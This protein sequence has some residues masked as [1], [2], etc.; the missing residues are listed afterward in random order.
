MGFRSLHAR[1]RIGK[2]APMIVVA[3]LCIAGGADAQPTWPAKPVRLV[4]PFPPGGG[5][6]ILGRAMAQR[7]GESVGQAVLL[8]NRP[9]AGGNLGAEI[10]ARAAPDGY[11]LVLVAPGFVISPSLYRKLGYDPFK[12][13]DPVSL[14][15]VIPNLIAVHPSVPAQ[16]VKDLVAFARAHPGKINFGSGGVGTSNHLA[17]ELLAVRTGISV[18]HVPYK[19]AATAMMDTVAGNVQLI[20]IG[21]GAAL[22]Q[23]K[24][25]KLRALA[26]LTPGRVPNAPEIPTIAE[27][28]YPGLEVQTWYAVFAPTKTPSAIVRRLNTELSRAMF[29][30]D[31]R[32]R[33][34]SI[35][36]EPMK[37][38]PEELAKF[39]REDYRRWADVIK[40]ANLRAEQ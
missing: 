18:V 13:F 34:A 2:S 35:G 14:V 36:A 20:T 15:A 28:G 32:E 4:L 26:T 19:G 39:I 24:A 23:V 6:D 7:L 8:D 38:S 16:S 3:A 17:T 33:L 27:A 21:T 10:V 30:P 22:A 40:S 11:T 37:S 29:E 25:G 5:T 9:G 31:V 1:H 12:D